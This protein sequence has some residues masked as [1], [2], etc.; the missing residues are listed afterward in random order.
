[1]TDKP[2]CCVVGQAHSGALMLRKMRLRRR[3]G[4]GRLM[5]VGWGAW[6]GGRGRE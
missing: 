4:I 6:G 1:M 3:G 2:S 5:N